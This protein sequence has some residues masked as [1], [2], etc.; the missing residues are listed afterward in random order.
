MSKLF[1]K[2]LERSNTRKNNAEIIAEELGMKPPVYYKNKIEDVD[3]NYIVS[4]NY[5]KQNGEVGYRYFYDENINVITEFINKLPKHN[6][7][8]FINTPKRKLYIDIDGKHIGNI[9]FTDNEMDKLIIDKFCIKFNEYF[10]TDINNNDLIIL[11]KRNKDKLINSIHIILPK[12]KIDYSIIKYFCETHLKMEHDER[13]YREYENFSLKNNK[14]LPEKNSFEK[15]YIKKDNFTLYKPNDFNDKDYLISYVNDCEELIKTLPAE[16]IKEYKK[17]NEPLKLKKVKKNGVDT[18]IINRFNIVNNILKFLKKHN[19]FYDGKLWIQLLISL[20]YN[21]CL[22]IEKFLTESPLLSTNKYSYEENKKEYDNI[23]ITKFNKD[24]NIVDIHYQIKKINTFYDTEFYYNNNGIEFSEELIEWIHQKT[25]IS[26]DIINEKFIDLN[27]NTEME[28]TKE[29]I[30]INEWKYNFNNYSLYNHNEAHTYLDELYKR[31]EENHSNFTIATREEI[32][33]KAIESMDDITIKL[34]GVKIVWCGGKSHLVMKPIIKKA[35][36]ENKKVLIYTEN[37]SLNNE[38]YND[39]KYNIFKDKENCVYH[40]LEKKHNDKYNLYITSLESSH[41]IK[42]YDFDLI[43]MDEY[44]SLINHLESSTFTD[45]NFTG[46]DCL[47]LMIKKMEKCKKIYCLDADLT[48]E[49]L[50]PLIKRLKLEDNEVLLYKSN[51]NKWRDTYK[52]NLTQDDEIGTINQILEDMKNNKK[53]GIGFMNVKRARKVMELIK[54]LYPNKNILSIWRDEKKYHINGKTRLL[55]GKESKKSINE[56]INEKDID[57][58]IYSPSVMTGLSYNIEFID[59]EEQPPRFNKT[60][61]FMNDGSCCARSAIQMLHRIRELKDKTIHINIDEKLKFYITPPT[62]EQIKRFLIDSIDFSKAEDNREKLIEY[63]QKNKKEEFI[64]NQIYQDFKIY[65]IKECF[66][67]V[68]NLGHELIRILHNNHNIKINFIKYNLEQIK[69]KDLEKS[70]NKSG[71]KATKELTELYRQTKLINNFEFK[72]QEKES[73]INTHNYQ[74]IREINKRKILNNFGLIQT[75]YIEKPQIN[76]LNTDLKNDEIINE[77]TRL[78]NNDKN[79]KLKNGFYIGKSLFIDKKDGKFISHNGKVFN[80]DTNLNLD[81]ILCFNKSGY[82][83]EKIG[84][85]K[86]YNEDFNNDIGICGLCNNIQN[87]YFIDNK[88]I[89]KFLNFNIDTFE[90]YNHIKKNPFTYNN[91]IEKEYNVMSE[92]LDKDNI[93]MITSLNQFNYITDK[94]NNTN[95]DNKLS[96]GINQENIFK[97]IKNILK[98]YFEEIFDEDGK[99]IIKKYVIKLSEWNEKIKKNKVLMESKTLNEIL[100]THNIIKQYENKK[101]TEKDIFLI[102]RAYLEM[103]GFLLTA[104]NTKRSDA[105][106]YMICPNN[107]IYQNTNKYNE[108]DY[109]FKIENEN[110]IEKLY[111]NDNLILERELK[112]GKSQIYNIGSGKK[113]QIKIKK[114]T[115]RTKTDKPSRKS[116]EAII[117]IIND[118]VKPNKRIEEIVLFKKPKMNKWIKENDKYTKNNLDEYYYDN[119]EPKENIKKIKSRITKDKDIDKLRKNHYIT[120]NKNKNNKINFNGKYWIRFKPKIKSNETII[121]EK[122]YYNK[123]IKQSKKL[124][125]GVCYINEESDDEEIIEMSEYESNALDK[126]VEKD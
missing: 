109:Y 74:S 117:N 47:E 43:V 45:E 120:N 2:E 125:S 88:N 79:T 81:N 5:Y 7:F 29:I 92:G 26:I 85:L 94:I 3:D 35:I 98:I 18:I 56:M 48:N 112:N 63:Y 14:K 49:R 124:K 99:F 76:L 123:I 19:K 78:F 28:K 110:D 71:V 65:N 58:W 80:K 101:I 51:W 21:K 52:Y 114:F 24:D 30:D 111:C 66:S 75:K 20:K 93:N 108:I 91:I 46:Y 22:N 17:K 113:Q 42:K 83:I 104:P 31:A 122:K 95:E 59:G 25:K 69:I 6:L 73:F 116:K 103:F 34:F 115:E 86:I 13:M 27:D 57:V 67:S 55:T 82:E 9:G 119:I 64:L 32:K 61:L 11:I 62:D 89:N 87:Y 23:D 37:N 41:Q 77:D 8:E 102:L 106:K 50:Q 118:K 97:K 72:K 39:F 105:D 68:L 1:L 33:R 53:V 4:Q 12:Y 100:D 10:E 54:T 84:K 44:E 121:L 70:I 36:D 60:Y 15:D 107:L 90:K 126:G 96:T 40:H 16:T 38:V